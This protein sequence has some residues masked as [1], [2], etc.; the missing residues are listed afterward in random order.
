MTHD[1]DLISF[2]DVPII[3]LDHRFHI[4]SLNQAFQAS[5]GDITGHYLPDYSANFSERKCQRKQASG[6]SYRFIVQSKSKRPI[7]FEIE[8]KAY[9]AGYY[10]LASDASATL[11]NEA[12]MASYS[13]MIEKQNREI[14]QKNEQLAIWGARINAEIDQAQTVQEL[15]VPERIQFDG[16]ESRCVP[17]RELSGDFHEIA[18]HE[19]G[20]ITF[21]SGDVAG[22]GIY[23]AIIMAQT[24]TAF[25]ACFDAPTLTHLARQ[26]V[27]ILED[28]FPDGLFVAMT[29]ARLSPD[30]KQCELLNLGN[31]D[32]L[33]IGDQADVRHFPSDGPAIGVLPADFYEDITAHHCPIDG[34]RLYI[35]SDGIL[36]LRLPDH[37]DGFADNKAAYDF[38]IQLDKSYGPAA[39][40]QL[41]D[42]A[43]QH[44]QIDDITLAT[45]GNTATKS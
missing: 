45:I 18:E 29:L 25:R 23:A 7:A 21:V 22:K 1:A 28:K 34:K 44:P 39:L 13:Q 27:T 41:F 37:E 35:F 5:F 32:A 24:L 36:D 8:L 11:R 3:T 43:K 16:I 33:L 9:E 2:F 19:D 40:A 20:Q 31:P 6:Q 38:L 14:V 30:K 15:L 4:T 26:I 10:G 17:L 12:L 42:L